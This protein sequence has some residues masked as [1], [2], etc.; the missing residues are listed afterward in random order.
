MGINRAALLI[1][2]ASLAL[3]SSSGREVPQFER[4]Y[5]LQPAEGVFAYA[6]ISPDGR[7]LAYA[8]EVADAAAPRGIAQTMTIVDLR[9][10]KAIFAERGIDGW[11][12]V[13]GRKMIFLS[14]KPGLSSVSI[15]DH[16]TGEVTRQ[17]APAN[18]GDYFS[19]ALRDGRN[20]I[21]TISSYYYY[22][23][24]DR[25]IMPPSRV[26]LCP[27]IGRGERPLISRDGQRITTFV[28]GTVV[29]RNLT[30]CDYVFDTGIGGAKADFSWDG[31]YIAFH[32]PKPK[33]SGYEILIVDLE[34]RTVRTLTDLPGS[35]LFPSWTRDGRVC[36]RYDGDDYR[37]FMIASDV[38]S[39]PERPLP[40]KAEHVPDRRLWDDVFPETEAPSHALELVMVW[41]AWS[42]HS[43]IALRTLDRARTYFE[44]NAL[45]V[46]IVTATDPGSPEADVARMLKRQGVRLPRIPLA[47]NRLRL[48]EAHN[49]VP[50]IL[51]FRN[52]ALV[53]RRL[54]AQTFDELRDWAVRGLEAQSGAS[55]DRGDRRR[56]HA[57][58]TGGGTRANSRWFRGLPILRLLRLATWP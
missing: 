5:S 41:S 55:V 19:W 23:D 49:Q 58:L 12:S 8:S 3:M 33:G 42:A 51:M 38:L 2:P 53:D 39:A 52:G 18:L 27:N 4:V 13:D 34:R 57:P 14:H 47:T 56:S 46:G 9:T 31:R 15:R 25:A 17:V 37:G 43:P 20:L 28:R 1:M 24:N 26:P 7:Y 22:L 21:L 40:K 29:V 10:K 45:D 30:D 35:S 36:F 16:G 11:F 50:V 32:A 48:T 44:R 54:G 6:R